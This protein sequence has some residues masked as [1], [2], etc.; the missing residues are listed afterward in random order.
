[1]EDGTT[2]AGTTLGT[3][4]GMIHG[5]TEAIGT[6]IITIADGMEAGTHIGGITIMVR[7]TAVLRDTTVLTSTTVR[8]TRQGPAG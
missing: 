3:E 5:T 6:T 8:D 7:D 2:A 1:M 4:D